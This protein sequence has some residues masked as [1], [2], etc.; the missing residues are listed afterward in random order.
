MNIETIRIIVEVVGVLLLTFVTSKTFRYKDI[1]VKLIEA[2]KD[3]KVTEQEF[4]A[5]VDE[6]KKEI[7][8]K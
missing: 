4:Q 1:A 3:M 2:A 5:I 7:Y 8:G 6:V